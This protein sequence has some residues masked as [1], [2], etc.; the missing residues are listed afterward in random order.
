[1]TAIEIRV[2]DIGDFK[3]VPV[4]EVLVKPGDVVKIDDAR[5]LR[6]E[7]PQRVKHKMP[8][9]SCA[10]ATATAARGIG[11]MQ[12]QA[13][14]ACLRGRMGEGCYPLRSRHRVHE[15]ASESAARST[16]RRAPSL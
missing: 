14:L 10:A 11:A 2:P 1:M 9:A 15:R 4:I 16:V 3:N 13:A 6:T 5:L 12:S 7:A 8:Q